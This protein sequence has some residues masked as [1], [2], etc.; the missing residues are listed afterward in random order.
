MPCI[1]GCMFGESPTGWF[2][3]LDNVQL[4]KKKEV[5]EVFVLLW[6][7]IYVTYTNNMS[8]AT[9]VMVGA[10]TEGRHYGSVTIRKYADGH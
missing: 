6:Y 9:A 1:K 4:T 8:W 7:M 3:I 2:Y 5:N 10:I